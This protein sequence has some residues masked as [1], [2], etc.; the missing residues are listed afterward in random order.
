MHMHTSPNRFLLETVFL[1]KIA[2]F[3]IY[4]NVYS[5]I[6]IINGYELRGLY[7]KREG[8]WPWRAPTKTPEGP[9]EGD[10]LTAPREGGEE[11]RESKS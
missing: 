7:Q 10:A 1:L 11:S 4:I 8:P 2:L 9:Q 5:N 3:S 6:K